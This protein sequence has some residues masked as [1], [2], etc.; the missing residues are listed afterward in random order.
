MK[1]L[2]NNPDVDNDKIFIFGRSLGGALAIK[3]AQN[4]DGEV[5]IC[6]F[7]VLFLNIASYRYVALSWKTLLRRF[8]IW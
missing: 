7:K 8:G 2:K 6:N 5:I 4:F 1:Y 3:L